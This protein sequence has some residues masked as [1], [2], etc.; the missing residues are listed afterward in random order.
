MTPSSPPP[1]N[2]KTKKF[3]KAVKE[4]ERSV[5]VSNLNLGK[6]PI[7]NTGTIAKK[8]TEDI[9]AKAAAA[10]G[11]DNGRPLEDT[12]TVL[13]DTLSV[14]KGMEFFGKATKLYTNKNNAADQLNRKFCTLPVKMVFKDKDSKTRAETVLRKTCKVQCTTPY[15]VQLR[16][17][18]KNTIDTYRDKFPDSFIQVKVDP[19]GL[20][21]KL[22]RRAK[23]ANAE[24][25]NNFEVI[26]LE[27]SVMDLGTVSNHPL[28][29][30]T[31]QE[32]AS[33]L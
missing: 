20:Q 6:V 16:E 21:L 11:K 15:Q 9:T 33:S 30:D 29:M 32:G 1:E 13:E 5:L 3:V 25:V 26:R 7:M 22:S 17:I 18:I 19:E 2:V 14:M 10:E 4:A 28:A 8:V 23:V 27:D 31:L 24:W 12:I